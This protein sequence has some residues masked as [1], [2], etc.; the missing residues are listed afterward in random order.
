MQNSDKKVLDAIFKYINGNIDGVIEDGIFN[1]TS[2]TALGEEYYKCIIDAVDGAK[3]DSVN[4]VV[5]LLGGKD[6]YSSQDELY[7]ELVEIIGYKKLPF[8]MLPIVRT[9]YDEIFVAKYTSVTGKYQHEIQKINIA[10]AQ[11][12]TASDLI[13]NKPASRSF[14]HDISSDEERL[15]QLCMEYNDL[16]TRKEM[17]EYI[18]Q[19]V[20]WSLREYCDLDDAI[21]SDGAIKMSVLSLCK[22]DTETFQNEYFRKYEDYLDILEYDIDNPDAIF[23]KI[24]LMP[25]YDELQKVISSFAHKSDE[26]GIIRCKGIK[27]K[28]PKVA[29]L[30]DKKKSNKTDYMEMLNGILSEFKV[31]EMLKNL[32]NNSVCMRNRK[33]FLSEAISVFDDGDYAVFN[34]VIPVQIEGLFADYLRDSTIFC[35]F[36]HLNIYEN[37]VLKDKIQF[38]ESLGDIMYPEAV[39][40]YK[41]YFNNLIRNRIAHGRYVSDSLID[42]EIFAKELLLDLYQLIRMM[43]RTSEIEKMYRFVHGYRSYYE[44]LIST[45]NPVYG[46]LFNDLIGSKIIAN[47]DSIEKYRPIQ[48][49]YWLLNPYY[50][51]IYEQVGDRNELLELRADLLNKAFW[52]YVLEKIKNVKSE[53]FDFLRIDPE[54]WAVVKGMFNSG[55]DDETKKVLAKINSMMSEIQSLQ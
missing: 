55:V 12:K 2:R 54:F 22:E 45:T 51:K 5:K 24:K 3:E 39:E 47:Y 9:K 49:A 10:L 28:I 27:D 8:E 42:D 26:K 7:A 11:N 6:D 34:N 1:A 48:V 29:D 18:V 23:F 40:Y 33:N 21:D 44:K 31:S 36:S 16:R 32:I 50:L 37:A 4:T 52:E 20:E 53:G 17:L 35:R 14:T 13:K 41:F 43:T 19:Y 30:L 46:A 15:Y 38:I 25:F